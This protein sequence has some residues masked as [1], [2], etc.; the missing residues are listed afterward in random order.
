MC[1]VNGPFKLC[2]CDSD[3][4]RKKPHW[5]LHRFIQ[6]REVIN[7]MG[8][9]YQPEPYVIISLRSLKRRL[10]S[11]NVFDFDYIPQDGD[12]QS[13][14]SSRAFDFF[15]ELGFEV[16]ESLGVELIDG[17]HPGSNWRGVKIVN[18]ELLPLIQNLLLEN[19]I[20]ANFKIHPNH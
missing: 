19:Q 20:N 15:H 11:I 5:I 18:I 2:T 4:D 13:S 1:D 17:S 6:S 16:Y 8:L 3:L 10:N 7:V 12:F 14:P 9:F